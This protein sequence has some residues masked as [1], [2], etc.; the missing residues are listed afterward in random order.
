MSRYLID[1][2]SHIDAPLSNFAVKAFADMAGFIGEQVCPPIP[3]NK[4]SDV[5]Y[6]IDKDSWLIIP[7]TSRAPKTGVRRGEWQASSDT[8]YAKNYA[9][10]TDHSKEAVANADAALR[11]RTNGVNFV[12]SALA[13][14]KEA[15]IASRVTSITNCGSGVALTGGNKFSDYANSDPISMVNTAHAFIRSQ[16]GL[17]ANT[18]A[19]D[20]DTMKTLKFHPVL[21]DY[22]KYTAGGA[23]NMD[24]LKAIF[25]VDEILVGDAIKNTA[26][27]GL[28]GTDSNIW[29]NNFLL[30]RRDPAPQ[31]LEVASFMAAMR[32]TPEGFPAPMAVE[33]Y[34]HHERSARKENVD[35]Q[36]YQDEKLIARDLSYLISNTL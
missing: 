17:R 12:L 7:E 20:Y 26:G 36:Y 3:V 15:R 25:E 6:T 2:G 31:S 23:L 11:V 27:E 16:T 24:Q 32:W 4:Q 35:V 8:Y 22:I 1:G 33:V 21:R 30:F 14:S 13:R 5:Y 29:G 19:M 18:I 34:D 28:T 9:F 10:G